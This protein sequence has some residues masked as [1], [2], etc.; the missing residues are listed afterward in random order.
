MTKNLLTRIFNSCSLK[1]NRTEQ[2]RTEQNRTEQNRTYVR[3]KIGE[4]AKLFI[5][6]LPFKLLE[7]RGGRHL[8]T[9]VVL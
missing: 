2:N 4:E 9:E 5:N 1:Q 6:L 3:S 7:K 8:A